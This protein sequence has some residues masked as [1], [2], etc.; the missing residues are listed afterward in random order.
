MLYEITINEK[1]D[2]NDFDVST[3]TDAINYDKIGEVIY[4]NTYNALNDYY[5]NNEKNSS[6]VSQKSFVQND[7]NIIQFASET[8]SSLYTV[9]TVDAPTTVAEQVGA[10]TLDIR[11]ILLLFLLVYLVITIYSKLKNTIINF[12]KG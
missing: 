3:N 9:S 11:N 7:E 4:Q 6:V 12:Y 2:N 1:D 10:Y 5:S 8:D